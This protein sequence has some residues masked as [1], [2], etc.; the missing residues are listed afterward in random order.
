MGKWKKFL[1]EKV[2]EY[3]QEVFFNTDYI[4]SSLIGEFI[5]ATYLDNIGNI[6]RVRGKVENVLEENVKDTETLN[7]LGG[8]Y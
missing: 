4:G 1:I 6:Q 7:L 5:E 2:N 3:P 8:N